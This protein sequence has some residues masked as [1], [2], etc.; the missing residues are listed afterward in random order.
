MAYVKYENYYS[1]PPV[2]QW[3]IYLLFYSAFFLKKKILNAV[4]KENAA[5]IRKINSR[6]SAQYPTEVIT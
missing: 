4:H 2:G 5:A 1:Q 3:W 6:K